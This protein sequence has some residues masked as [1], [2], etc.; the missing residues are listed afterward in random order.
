MNIQTTKL[1]DG[2]VVLAKSYKGRVESVTY[3]NYTQAAR[4]VTELLLA[5][6]NARVL[7]SAS[8]WGEIIRIAIEA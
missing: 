7:R 2:T 8:G 5:G 1:N 6:I 4:K 3:A